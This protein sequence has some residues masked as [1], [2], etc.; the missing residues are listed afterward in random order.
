M[1]GGAKA[2]T[3]SSKREIFPQNILLEKHTSSRTDFDKEI[4]FGLNMD[5]GHLKYVLNNNFITN[6]T[7][8]S[9]CVIAQ[10]RLHWIYQLP[11][12]LQI[13]ANAKVTCTVQEL[14]IFTNN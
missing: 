3:H 8:I 2:R 4:H 7:F 11:E 14:D 1:A 12:L 9:K 13:Y 10:F 6:C 5:K